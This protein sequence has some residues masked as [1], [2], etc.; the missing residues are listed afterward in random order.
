[1]SALKRHFKVI[2]G[3]EEYGLYTS[4][5]P[6]SAAKKAVSKLCA[7]NKNKKVEFSLRETTQESN[8]KIYGPYIGYMQKLD[9][10]VE[11]EGRVIRYKPIVKRIAKK[12]NQVGGF[13]KVGD[14]VRTLDEKWIDFLTEQGKKNIFIVKKV[15]PEFG[16]ILVKHIDG[17]RDNFLLLEYVEKIG[18]NSAFANVTS[19]ASAASA[20]P[21]HYF[22]ELSQHINTNAN[23]LGNWHIPRNPQSPVIVR[24]P[25]RSF[26]MADRSESNSP[27]VL[28][29]NFWGNS[30]VLFPEENLIHDPDFDCEVYG[31][32]TKDG[33]LFECPECLATA[34]ES[35]YN[36]TGIFPHKKGCSNIG[37]YCRF[38]V[39]A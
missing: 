10:P 35:N 32:R 6:S 26:V 25:N 37:K 1:M 27:V 13:I 12:N 20:A 21:R 23:H 5:T 9:K 34:L 28:E 30:P 31:S 2:I 24:N 7:D 15:H 38:V 18:S 22:P 29:E 39:S 33:F 11:L 8:K 17:G 36:K 16:K 4:S 14:K 19:A 3:N